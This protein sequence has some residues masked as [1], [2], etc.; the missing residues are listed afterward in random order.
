MNIYC[1]VCTTSLSRF[2]FFL[3]REMEE[4]L[5]RERKE[6]ELLALMEE[7]KLEDDKWVSDRISAYTKCCIGFENHPMWAHHRLIY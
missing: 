6:K 4:R 5:E 3:N 2:F 1:W 7:K